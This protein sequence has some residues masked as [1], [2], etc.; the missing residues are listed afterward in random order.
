MLLN[1]PV[2]DAPWVVCLCA[3]WCGTCRDYR[4][5]MQQV[6]QAHPQMRFAWVDIEDHAELADEFD[7]ETFPTLL[8]VDAGGQRFLGP[9]LPN[10]QALS[11]LLGALPAAQPAEAHVHALIAGIERDPAAFALHVG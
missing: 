2:S 4:P 8:V 3:E 6:A 7:V 9:M 11:R 1:P 5:L 10:A